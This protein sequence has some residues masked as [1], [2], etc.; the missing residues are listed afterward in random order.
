MYTNIVASNA[1]FTDPALIEKL[2]AEVIEKFITYEV[3]F[4]MARESWRAFQGAMQDLREIDD[5]RV[6][7]FKGAGISSLSAQRV[8]RTHDVRAQRGF[9]TFRLFLLL[10]A[11]V[12][13]DRNKHVSM[14]N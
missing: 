3:P 12:H 8:W 5:L 14:R 1:S 13:A 11:D 2:G 4:A 6:L 10:W 7:D 9:L